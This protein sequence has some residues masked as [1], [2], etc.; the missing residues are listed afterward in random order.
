MKPFLFFK[1]SRVLAALLVGIT[2]L[3]S[4][5]YLPLHELAHEE[6]QELDQ[7]CELCFLAESSRDL[8]P[9]SSVSLLTVFSFLFVLHHVFLP[10]LVITKS[11][12]FSYSRAPPHLA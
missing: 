3:F 8:L 9:F 6:S 2:L 10:S 1:K 7:T 5:A 12:L 4:Q 11:Y